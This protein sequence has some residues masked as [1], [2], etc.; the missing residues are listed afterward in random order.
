M[1]EVYRGR[2]SRGRKSGRKSPRKYSKGRKSGRKYSKGRKS[3][4]YSRSRNRFRGVTYRSGDH[5]NAEEL[6]EL[7]QSLLHYNPE[8]DRYSEE[9]LSPSSPQGA[10]S[11]TPQGATSS[12]PQ[13]ATPDLATLT[14]GDLSEHVL[15]AFGDEDFPTRKV[16]GSLSFREMA[17]FKRN[18][19]HWQ[20]LQPDVQRK[21]SDTMTPEDFD[22]MMDDVGNQ[23]M[24]LTIGDVTEFNNRTS[25]RNPRSRTRGRQ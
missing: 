2:K 6:L 11:S 18:R 9:L 25:V 17:E 23:V 20:Y 7:N 12:T 22:E 1:P 10:T 19:V 8:L 16:I 24:S 15:D 5:F 14:P 4:R 3:P 13:G 21:I